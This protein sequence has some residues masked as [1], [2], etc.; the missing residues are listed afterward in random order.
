MERGWLNLPYLA[1]AAIC[2]AVALA[3]VFVWPAERAT[4][5][6]GLRFFFIRWGHALVWAL[7]GAMC[8]MKASGVP[9]LV[10]WSNPVG[11]AAVPVY[12]AFLVA[13]FVLR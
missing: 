10:S 1:W 5:A 4:S 6:D 9:A 12:L 3:W 8:L 11:L 2:L 13:T 7:L